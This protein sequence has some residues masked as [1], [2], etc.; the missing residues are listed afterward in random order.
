MTDESGKPD[1]LEVFAQ[2]VAQSHSYTE[3]FQRG[4]WVL[5]RLDRQQAVFLTAYKFFQSSQDVLASLSAIREWLLDNYYILQQAVQQIRQDMPAGFYRRLP[6]L[7]APPFRDYP[8]SFGVAW[9]FISFSQVNLDVERLFCFIQAYQSVQALKIAELWS[10]PTMLRF[11]V[12]EMVAHSLAETTGQSYPSL[13]SGCPGKEKAAAEIIVASGITSLRTLAA[14][15]WNTFFDQASLTEKI[16]REDPAQVY[17]RMTF[18]T[19]DLYRHAVEEIAEWCGLGEIEVAKACVSMA[20]KSWEITGDE[21]RRFFKDERADHIGWYLV[22]EGR[23]YLEKRLGCRPPWKVIL[24]RLILKHPLF[25]YLGGIALLTAFLTSVWIYYALQTGRNLGVAILAGFLT[26]LPMMA[27][28]VWLMNRLVIRV[29]PPRQLPRLEFKDGIPAEYKTI[30]VVPAIISEPSEVPSLLHQ[31]ELHYLCNP[32]PNLYFALLGD[33]ADAPEEHSKSDQQILRSIKAGIQAL[34]AKYG[35]HKRKPFLAFHRKRQWNPSED[36]WMGWERKRGKLMEFNRLALGEGKTSF[37]LSVGDLR[38]LPQI[39][40]VI[41][42]DSD[43]I[44]QR[45]SARRLVATIAHPLNQGVLDPKSGKLKQG[46]SIL[47]PRVQVHPASA[48]RSL[49]TR[50]FAGDSG[51][52]LY[53]RVVSEVYQDLFGESNYVGKGLYDLRIFQQTLKNRIPENQVVSHDLLEGIHGKVAYVSDI[54]IYEDYPPHWLAY[55]LRLHRWVR[56]DWQVLPWLF[57]RIPHTQLGRIAND[58]S[59]LSRWK[60]FD[61]L[62]RSLLWPAAWALMIA[63]W[64]ILPGYSLLWSLAALLPLLLPILFTFLDKAAVIL[65]RGAARQAFYSIWMEIVHSLLVLTFLPH[66][67]LVMLDAILTAFVRMTITRKRLL[68]W[69]TAAH[70]VK[71]FGLHL[72]ARLAW[73]QLF[74]EPIFAVCFAI[75]LAVIKPENLLPALPFLALWL[76]APQIL[77]WSCRFD[78]KQP[79]RLKPDQLRELQALAYRTWLYFRDYARPDDHWLPPDHFQE[80]PRGIIAHHTSPTNIGLGLLATV[81]AYDLGATGLLDLTLRL[82]STFD[83]LGRMEHY[84]GHL[85]NWYDT[86]SLEPLPPRYISTVDSGNL[87]GALITL[88]QACRGIPA[89]PLFRPQRFQGLIVLLSL[90]EDQVNALPPQSHGASLRKIT[91]LLADIQSNLEAAQSQPLAWLETLDRLQKTNRQE[92]EQRFLE[93]LAEKRQ[94]LEFRHLQELRYWITAFRQQVDE[95]LAEIDIL[96]P[97]MQAFAQPPPSL[98]Q[99]IHLDSINSAWQALLSVFSPHLN[100]EGLPA[101]CQSGKRCLAQ[102]IGAL[103]SLPQSEKDSVHFMQTDLDH[104]FMWCLDLQ[105]KLDDTENMAQRILTTLSAVFQQAEERYRKM[106]FSFL[107]NPRRRVFYIGYNVTS[108]RLDNNHYDLLASEARLASLLAIAKGD[109]PQEHWL[110]LGRPLTAINGVRT[111]LSWSGTMFEYLMPHLFVRSAPNTLLDQSC[112]SAVNLQI[113]YGKQNGVPWGI[114]ESGYYHFDDHLNY[115]YRAFG[116]PALAYKRGLEEELVIAPYASLL[117]LSIS[118]REVLANI[119]DLRRFGALGRYG[120]YEA[121][122]FTTS[123]MPKGL[124]YGVVRSYLAHHQ[125]M[126]L[127]S[128]TNYLLDSVMQNRFHADTSVE[129]IE[130]LTQEKVSES[131]PIEYPRPKTDEET[132]FVQQRLALQAWRPQLNLSLP[133]VHSLS[134]GHYSVL[135][136]NNGGGYSQWENLQLTRWRSDTT[137]DDWGAWIYIK[138][139]ETGSLWSLCQQPVDIPAS[140]YDVRFSPHKV[141]FE[142]RYEDLAAQ[143]TLV[144]HPRD[145]VEIRRLTITNHSSSTRRLTVTSYGELVLAAPQTDSRHPV[146]NKLFIQSE[147]YAERNALLF[148]RRMRSSDETPVFL[149]HALALETV[150]HR[151]KK[152]AIYQY[153]T[154]RE[155]FIGRGGTIRAPRR[156]LQEENPPEGEVGAV[157]DPIF[158]LTHEITLGPNKTTHLAFITACASSRQK[159]IDLISNYQDWDNLRHVVEEAYFSVEQDLQEQNIKPEDISRFQMLLSALFYPTAALRAEPGRLMLNS[160][161]Q[162]GLWAYSISGDYPILL[163]KVWQPEHI[164]LVREVLQAYT[165]WRKQGLLIDLVL[166]NQHETVYEQELQGLLYRVLERNGSNLWLNQRGGIFLLKAGQVNETDKILLESVARVILDGKKGSLSQQLKALEI[167]PSALP[168]ALFIHPPREKE[169][170]TLSRPTGLLFDNGLGGFHPNGKEYIVYL[171]GDQQTPA[172]WINVIANPDLGFLVS[173]SGLGCTWSGNSGENRLTPWHN[174]PLTDPPAEIVYLRDEQTGEFWSATPQPIREAEPYLV[175]HGAGYSIFEHESHGLRQRLKVFAAVDEPVKIIQV[176]LDNAGREN[177]QIVITYYAEWVLG[178]TRPENACFILPEFSPTYHALLARNPYNLDFSQRVAFL[179][180]TREPHGL[181]TDRS[182]FL[183]NLGN[184]SHPKALERV[185]LSACV[186]AGV[187]PCAVMQ[188]IL[189]LA[190][191][192]SKEVTFLLGQGGDR[193]EALRLID[194]YHDFKNVEQAWKEVND[195]WDQLLGGITVKSPDPALNLLFNRWLLYQTLACRIWGRTALY[196]SSGAYGFRDQ[197]QDVLALAHQLPAIPREMILK[198][199]RHQFPEG[200]VLH[201]WHPPSP[202][203]VRSR[204]SDDYLWLPYVTAE[205]TAIRG[206]HRILDEAAEYLDGPALEQNELERYDVYRRNNQADPLYEH[207]VKAIDLAVKNRNFGSHGLPLIGSSDWNDGMNRIGHQG[208][209]ESVWLGWFLLSVL[210]RFIIIAESRGDTERAAQYRKRLEA[211]RKAIEENGWDEAW[212]LRAFFDDGTPLGSKKNL[213]CQI[214]AIAQSWAVLCGLADTQRAARAMEAVRHR[215]VRES[216]MV[217]AL[218]DPPFDKSE[219]D[220]GYIKGYPPGVRENGGQYT[221]AAVWTAWAFAELGHGDEVGRLLRIL[222]PIYHADTDE[223]VRQFRLEPYVMPADVYSQPPYVGRGG[224]SWYTGSAGWMYRLCLEA[225]F[226]LKRRGDSLQID[227]CIPAEWREFHLDYKLDGASY[228][229]HVLNPEGVQKGVS[230]IT[231]DGQLLKANTLPLARDGQTHTVLIRMGTPPLGLHQ[232]PID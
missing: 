66:H 53:S 170:V 17:H 34:N 211:L 24:K 43:C 4:Y 58:L 89:E 209:G 125:G 6:K 145:D 86:R 9:A 144:V 59:R 216:E 163:V 219:L 23:Q 94:V 153:E 168:R 169:P 187:D 143:M 67:A 154:N 65:A 232:P 138:D 134:N 27:S 85:Y 104:L 131:A 122:D 185:G 98:T 193:E 81:A 142:R 162:P 35:T 10:L 186:Q 195:Y 208:K 32:D 110:Y 140:H 12:L 36:C 128:L 102:L 87:A 151:L 33:F 199:A 231:L 147:F 190:P 101:A 25:S 166:L 70:N 226:G 150:D 92:L 203:G 99:L 175:R 114:S 93:F 194:K 161:S 120:L 16:L 224:W 177:R 118:P 41:T 178:A 46:Y 139:E 191:G 91:T 8:R 197:L 218:F 167:K 176:K 141:D 111:L 107:Y 221:H 20:S 148:S 39:R 113:A 135:I 198:A 227:P 146:F 64:F 30:V 11:S 189:W 55:I 95:W 50:A 54:V 228:H 149:G 22:E 77:T 164:A 52:D 184:Y 174:D 90:L 119:Q 157:L 51:L 7:T 108:G 21:Q 200:D 14:Q 230:E 38:V 49:F 80:E 158:S 137:L 72:V 215:L 69:T 223:K 62:W 136:T 45:E 129:S 220:P 132:P 112:R 96:M 155:K 202:R 181:T 124:A 79:P 123:R 83:T 206:D 5:N 152:P 15:D 100:L 126:I 229:F 156:L 75:L 18:E 73:R 78:E 42:L 214:D 48:N 29:F 192:S 188:V 116:V 3:R 172:P 160:K 47:Q 179:A 71:V 97:W 37:I 44:L 183:G 28:A 207:C 196:Q 180:A 225:V 106:D 88:K 212:Y 173:E 68:Q 82:Q 130:L 127:L 26:L 171:E 204:C 133:M 103:S 61:N 222:N 57:H 115:Q 84:R 159:V 217:I 109:V 74:G 210:K 76:I 117:A 1:Q 31:L 105:R 165:Y 60:I 201:W 63:G 205:F 182:E 213:E 40:Y 56:G 121:V 13:P 19:R 2:Q